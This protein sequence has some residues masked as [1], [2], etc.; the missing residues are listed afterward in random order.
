MA[1][2]EIIMAFRYLQTIPQNINKADEE[3][4]LHPPTSTQKRCYATLAMENSKIQSPEEVHSS[5][6]HATQTNKQTTEW[7]HAVK[8]TGVKK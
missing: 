2:K 5:A 7:Q 8:Q 6:T 1:L 4:L 3:I